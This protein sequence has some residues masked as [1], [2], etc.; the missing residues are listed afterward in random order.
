MRVF[1]LSRR[2]VSRAARVLLVAFSLLFAIA[3]AGNIYAPVFAQAQSNAADLRGF[4]RDPQGANVAGATV[5][6]SNP[7]TGIT[8]T[9]TTNDEGFY[10]IINLPP[11][12]YQVAVEG[13]NFKRAVLSNVVLTVGQ[14]A[15]LDVALELGGVGESVTIDASTAIELV[16][17][18]RTSVSTTIEEQR[19]ENLPINERSYLNFALTTSNVTRDNAR[20]TGPIPTSGLNVN[21]QRARSNLIQVDGVDFTTNGSGG[22]RAAVSQEAVQEFQVTTNSFA[23]EFGRATGAVVNVVTKGGTNNLDGTVF[24]FIRNRRFDARNALAPVADPPFTRAQYGATV[25][26]PLARDRVFFLGSFE[27]RRRQESGFFTSNV[28]EGLGA[29]LPIG[30]P[31]LPFTQTYENLTTGQAAYI[32]NLLQRAGQAAAGG[33]AAASQALASTAIAYATFASSGGN[34]ALTGTNPLRSPGG[35]LPITAGQVIG[36]RFVLSGAPVPLAATDAQGRGLAFR[37]LNSLAG[38]FPISESTTFASGRLDQNINDANQF[39]LRVAYNPSRSTGRQVESQNQSQGQNDFSR[40]GVL[41]IRDSAAVATLTSTLS[42]RIVNEA[43]FNFGR[44]ALTFTSGVGD[45][46][47]ANISGRAFIGRELFS[48]L[49]S[50]ETRYQYLDNINIVAGN[51]TLKFGADINYVNL[52]AAF[53]LN[54]AGVFNFGGLPAGALLA[55]NFA[56]LAGSGLPAADVQTLI[57]TAPAF[58]SVQQYGLGFPANY[59][60]GFGDPNSRIRNKPFGFFGQDSW[61]IRPNL[62]LNYGVRYDIEF[63]EQIAPI[64]LT[65]R[66]SGI[67]LSA[68]Q[69]RAAQDVVGVQ[70]GFPRDKNNIAPRLG[71]AYDITNDGRTVLRAAYGLFYDRPVLA[72]AINSDI[73]D[74]TQAPQLITTPNVPTPSALLNA[75]QIFQGTV[76]PGVTPGVALGTNYLT[77]RQRFDDQTFPGFGTALSFTLPIVKNFE[78][79]LAQQANLGIERQLTN[80]IS[81]SASYLFVTSRHLP[82][83][84]DINPPNNALITENFRRFAGRNPTSAAEALT[85]TLPT[86]GAGVIIPGLLFQNANGRIIAPAA[87]NFFRPNA[88]NYFLVQSLTGGAVT[89]AVFNNLLAGTLRT[90]GT[91]S[92]FGAIFAQVSDANSTY[93]AGTFDLKKRFSNNFQFL[94]SYTLAHT[95]DESSD[96]Q[97]Q[98]APQDSFNRRAERADS[99]FDQRH[100]F[101]FS[102]VLIAP[103]SFRN[104][105]GFRSF[106]AD[107]NVAPIFE[108]GTGRPFNILT[109]TDTNND[110]TSQTDRPSLAGSP[111]CSN[112]S[113]TPLCLPTAFSSGNL[114]RN[115]GI[116]GNFASF[117]LRVSRF[118]RVSEAVRID[119]IAE[120]FNLFNRFN[121]AAASPLYLDVNTRNETLGGRFR[122]RTTATFDPRQFQFGLKLN[123]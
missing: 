112:S 14:R 93:N 7:A 20:P 8:R 102:G 111:N 21:G 86:T 22:A 42:D 17:T 116:T 114:G 70:Q 79:P 45:A 92:P 31:F 58:T 83:A 113:E 30:A 12:E 107:F 48:P 95:I 90:P 73:A 15:D 13:T 85:F 122:S 118:I 101:V 100:R 87:A 52:R 89:P 72:T 74:A 41:N 24:G 76:V 6:A 27:Q 99:V 36:S 25:G 54:F 75:T 106:L 68:D 91:V 29:T 63:Q 84:V 103:N 69:I 104:A 62:T 10:Q 56:T 105:G 60:Q 38:V 35:A 108:F 121:E 57:A 109:N 94:A 82:R 66:L 16:E 34:T 18:S 1:H 117:D 19:I 96:L 81:I 59:Q 40:T 5:T 51:H 49:D 39:S 28:R 26:G 55:S 50:T 3:L 2:V 37:P 33:N 67:T 65:D 44:Q 110:Q 47:A 32:T 9:A 97:S 61:K 119:I 80:D 123:F 11:G 64:G 77:G 98:F 88:P 46:V 78:Y 23:A 53:Q 43:R 4:V 120:G 71:L 115:R